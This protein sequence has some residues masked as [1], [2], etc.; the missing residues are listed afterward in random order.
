MYSLEQ[1][2]I[3]EIIKN[4]KKKSFTIGKHVKVLTSDGIVQGK[5]LRIDNDGALV[6][7]QNKKTMRILVGDVT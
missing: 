7:S 4:W 6:I 2:K 5:A 1:R 3:R